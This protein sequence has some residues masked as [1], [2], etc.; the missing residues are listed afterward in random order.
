MRVVS[1]PLNMPT[2]S[3]VAMPAQTPTIGP[4]AAM[5]IAT[6]TVASPATAPTERSISPAESTK[7][8]AIAITAIIAV[9]RTML[10]R[11]LGLRN[12]LSAKVTA[13][14]RKMTTKPI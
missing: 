8:M 11:L 9:C 5:P 13:K 4:P 6:V 14:T 7:V 12:P 10:S 3:P 2:A 1:Q